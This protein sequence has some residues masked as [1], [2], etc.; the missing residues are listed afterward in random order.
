MRALAKDPDERYRLGR[1]D[2]RRPR[3]RRARRRGL[4]A[5]RGGDD[6]GARR[7]R[8][9][10]AAA[11]RWSRARAPSP[12]PPAPPAYR[13]PTADYE[14]PPR[15]RSPWPWLLGLLALVDR[16][17][18]GLPALREDPGPAERRTEPVTVVDV[19]QLQPAPR[20]A[21]AR[22][23]GLPGRA[24]S[25]PSRAST[26]AKS[27]RSSR[28]TRPAA[29]RSAEG[30]DGDAH[31]STGQP[32]VDRPGRRQGLTRDRRDHGARAAPGSIANPVT[33]LL[34][35]AAEH[36]DRR[37]SPRPGRSC[38]QGSTVR[39]NV[40]QGEKP[41]PVPDV[42]GQPYANAAS[43]LQGAGFIVARVD[44]DSDRARRAVVIAQDPVA[45]SSVAQRL[46]G[47]ASRSRRARRRPSPGR[48][49]RTQADAQRCSQDAGFKST[50]VTPGRDRPEP[51]RPRARAGSGG[52]P[53]E[54]KARA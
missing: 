19:G 25:R 35:R 23:A 8:D 24:R 46:D 33:R 15:R 31:V 12:T 29:E 44:V 40:S 38:S 21:E 11:R 49:R 27:A 36:R 50:V 13:P 3:A 47:D 18:D 54:K 17:R 16:R 34:G 28:R 45:G 6:P 41:V 9:A 20:D 51:G 4:A 39:I 37:R 10:T 14:E 5:D 42:V 22:G 2:G 30:I 52:G 1:G 26:V 32:E 7:R 48:H 43:A 53:L